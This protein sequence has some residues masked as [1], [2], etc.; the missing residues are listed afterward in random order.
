MKF[1]HGRTPKTQQNFSRNLSVIEVTLVSCAVCETV[2]SFDCDRSHLEIGISINRES[3][4]VE[5][6]K[7]LWQKAGLSAVSIKKKYDSA[8]EEYMGKA[9]QNGSGEAAQNR[10]SAP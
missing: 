10:K 6:N 4:K 5:K 3:I 2:N 1:R 7:L 9:A 8:K